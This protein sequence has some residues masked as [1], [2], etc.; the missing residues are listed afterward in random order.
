MDCLHH[1]LVGIAG[2]V[3]P[4]QNASSRADCQRDWI[5]TANAS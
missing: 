3:T 1:A 2:P 4:L 5:C